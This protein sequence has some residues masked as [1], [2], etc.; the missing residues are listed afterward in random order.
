MAKPI[1]APTSIAS[2]RPIRPTSISKLRQDRHDNAE[3]DG[4]DEDRDEDEQGGI[5][6][7]AVMSYP[8]FEGD[9]WHQK[10]A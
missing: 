1:H 4:I 2:D 7:T 8:G 3:P 9:R 10:A 5:V 6:R